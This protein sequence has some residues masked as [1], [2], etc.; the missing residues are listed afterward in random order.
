MAANGRTTSLPDLLTGPVGPII[1]AV[2]D[3]RA[4]KERSAKDRQ[5]NAVMVNSN[6]GASELFR[7]LRG[8]RDEP[9]AKQL[10][11]LKKSNTLLAGVKA[12]LEGME[13]IEIK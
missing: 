13:V 2:L 6:E 11:E 3:D 1:A 8:S 5:N 10:A 4:D 7:L 9:S 12:A